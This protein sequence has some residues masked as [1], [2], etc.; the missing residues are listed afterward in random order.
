MVPQACQKFQL[1]SKLQSYNIT[2]IYKDKGTG[3]IKYK[4]TRQYINMVY[5]IIACHKE[6]QGQ[7]VSEEGVEQMVQ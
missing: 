7:M 5:Y 6:N 2:N 4:D 1:A 3:I